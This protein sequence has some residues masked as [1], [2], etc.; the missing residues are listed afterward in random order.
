VKSYGDVLREYEYHPEAKCADAEGKLCGK[1]TIGL[2]QRRHIAIDGFDYIGKESNKLEQVEEGAVPAESDVYTIYADPQ[3]DEWHILLPVLKRIPLPELERE[4]KLDRR[5]L[6]RI[7]S[8]QQRP[9]PRN[10]AAL[11][12]AVAARRHDT[13]H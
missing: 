3:R 2:L 1:Q 7:R 13:N 10:E 9:H 11:R 12:R 4:S 6:Q 5:T 8:G